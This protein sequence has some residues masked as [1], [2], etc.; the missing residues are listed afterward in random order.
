MVLEE[1]LV[2]YN[3]LFGKFII[4]PCVCKKSIP[5]TTRKRIFLVT[6]SCPRNVLSSIAMDSDVMPSARRSLPSATETKNCIGCSGGTKES[7]QYNCLSKRF[8]EEPIS[9]KTVIGLFSKLLDARH[10][11]SCKA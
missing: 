4:P 2:R 1:E 5:N 6:T 11:L 10:W 8:M 3:W 7:K 9:F